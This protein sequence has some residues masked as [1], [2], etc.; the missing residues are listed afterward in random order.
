MSLLAK[1]S[2]GPAVSAVSPRREFGAYEALWLEPGAT[3]K[4]LAERF[5]A[6]FDDRDRVLAG[7]SAVVFCVGRQ[8]ERTVGLNTAAGAGLLFAVLEEDER[9]GKAGGGRTVFPGDLAFNGVDAAGIA[10]G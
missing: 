4:S 2:S 10:A 5:A 1:M 3:F 9:V 6:D 7:R 8:L